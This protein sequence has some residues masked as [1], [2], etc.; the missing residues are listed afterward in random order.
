MSIFYRFRGFTGFQQAIRILIA[1]SFLVVF[2]NDLWLAALGYWNLIINFFTPAPET[3]AA[4][5]KVTTG[6][7]LLTAIYSVLTFW[8]THFVLPIT[9]IE[10]S[11]PGFWRMLLHGISKG[12]LH[13][14]AVFVR[15]GEV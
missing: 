3:S 4:M 7:M 9:H 14:P 6:L 5:L 11:F 1:L 8:L 10:Q 2:R 12:H 15:N 13:G